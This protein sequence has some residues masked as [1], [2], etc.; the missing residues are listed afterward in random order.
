MKDIISSFN[1]LIYIAG[2][3]P[4]RTRL[5]QISVAKFYDEIKADFD[6][7]GDT[8]TNAVR[9]EKNVNYQGF[10]IRRK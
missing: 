7:H 8:V 3:T 4:S 10:L 5:Y 9:F 6:L 1:Q 2:S